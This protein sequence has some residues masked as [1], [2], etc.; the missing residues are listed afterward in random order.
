[1]FSSI[2][3]Y[4]L[5][6]LTY[7]STKNS[8]IVCL[9]T[10]QSIPLTLFLS[11]LLCKHIHP[12]SLSH[13]HSLTLYLS[14]FYPFSL[15][16]SLSSISH[17]TY[18]SL[19]PFIPPHITLSISLPSPFPFPPLSLSLSLPHPSSLSLKC[20]YITLPHVC[21]CTCT[22]I[23]LTPHLSLYYP[24]LSLS[25]YIPSSPFIYL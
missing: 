18:L 22:Q 9:S 23:Y 10:T 11:P 24:L 17:Y 20:L 8:Q 21:V 25:L 16:Y 19:P 6:P 15:D 4:P 2:S 7:P 13:S 5:S 3:L 14:L 1:M 12:L